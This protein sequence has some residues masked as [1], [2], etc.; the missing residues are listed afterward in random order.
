MVN[1]TTKK[2]FLSLQTQ[3]PKDIDVCLHED[4]DELNP[5]TPTLPPLLPHILE[6]PYDFV[7]P[8]STPSQSQP[9]LTPSRCQYADGATAYRFIHFEELSVIA[10]L[11]DDLLSSPSPS[12][13]SPLLSS[14]HVS[15]SPL[16][17]AKECHDA[18]DVWP[19]Y[20]EEGDHQICKLCQ[21]GDKH[22]NAKDKTYSMSTGS[23]SLCHHLIREHLKL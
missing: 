23:T 2:T 15:V 9:A 20:V 22:K 19:F 13:A 21:V 1:H 3:M 16:S 17:S 12:L 18:D 5:F 10:L 8:P 11:P 14:T 7:S 6:G 4:D